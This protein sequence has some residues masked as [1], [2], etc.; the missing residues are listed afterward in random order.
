MDGICNFIGTGIGVGVC[1]L[2]GV[3]FGSK[4]ADK[5]GLVQGEIWRKGREQDRDYT[6]S[7]LIKDT[8]ERKEK[9]YNH[10]SSL[11]LHRVTLMPHKRCDS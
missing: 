2:D 3:Q 5:F 7:I 6:G 10:L 9:G 4:G 11:N 8:A 1:Y